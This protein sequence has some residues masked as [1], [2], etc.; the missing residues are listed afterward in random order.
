MNLSTA[1]QYVKGPYGLAAFAILAVFTLWQAKLTFSYK[2]KIAGI[3]KARPLDA[4]Q[5][6]LNDIG[7]PIAANA[8]NEQNVLLALEGR[9]RHVQKIMAILAV[10]SIVFLVLIIASYVL[11]GSSLTLNLPEPPSFPPI[12]RW[13]NSQLP[14]NTQIN[15]NASIAFNKNLNKSVMNFNGNDAYI[16]MPASLFPYSQTQRSMVVWVKFRSFEQGSDESLIL[17]Y[18]RFN[19][20]EGGCYAL[21]TVGGGYVAFT[22]WGINFNSPDNIS[23]LTWHQIVSSTDDESGFPLTSLYVDGKLV[24]RSHISLDTPDNTLLYVGDIPDIPNDIK[25]SVRWRNS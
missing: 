21:T 11:F 22:N 17:G 25:S 1:I 15:G 2:V 14:P 20:P 7:F 8:V 4:P 9:Y 19:Y 5:I 23:A 18:G 6:A 24:A 12:F 16:A 10:T 13:N 3:K